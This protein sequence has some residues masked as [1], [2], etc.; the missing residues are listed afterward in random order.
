MAD[1]RTDTSRSWLDGKRLRSRSSPEEKRVPNFSV[2]GVKRIWLAIFVAA[3]AWGLSD[4][5]AQVGPALT[6]P[7]GRIALPGDSFAPP[8]ANVPP[9]PDVPPPAAGPAP[10]SSLAAASSPDKVVDVKV[11]GN[12]SLPLEKILPSIRTRAGRPFDLELIQE[13]V[14]RLDHTHLFVTVKTYWQKVPGGR[15]VI[16][17]VV[18]RP[19]LRSVR[20][21]GCYEIRK[22]TLQKESKL[23][24]GDPVDPISIEE[25]RRAIEEL[26]RTHGFNNATIT[27]LEGSKPEDRHAIFIIDEGVKQ[28]VVSTQ[29]IGNTIASDDRLRTQISTSRALFGVFGGE[30]DRKKLEED[31]EKLTAYY[32]GLGF[33]RARIGRELQF[34][35]Q[36][37]RVT[38]VFV[39]DEG[40]RYKVR[41]VS[42]VG[43]K[44]YTSEELTADLKLKNNQYFNQAS[45][46]FDVRSLQDKYGGDGYVFADIKP[47]PRFLE[48]PGQLDLVYKIAE[49]DR[50]RVGK[51]NIHIKGEY[52]HTQENTVRNR[53]FFKPG[54]IVD[55]RLI[56]ASEV[57]LKRCGLFESN[58]AQGNAP[59]IA[60]N[61]PDREGGNPEDDDRQQ[62]AEKPQAG[63][64]PGTRF[65]GQ[66]PDGASR[67]RVLDLTLECGRYIGPRAEPAAQPKAG[68][69]AASSEPPPAELATPPAPPSCHAST[70]SPE[71][72]QQ[73]QEY[74]E[75]LSRAKAEQRTRLQYLAPDDNWQGRTP[76]RNLAPGDFAAPADGQPR[77]EPSDDLARMAREYSRAVSRIS[78]NTTERQPRGQL[79]LTQYSPDA[80]RSTPTGNDS[81]RWW[82]PTQTAAASADAPRAPATD[83]NYTGAQPQPTAPAAAGASGGLPPTQV[84]PATPAAPY[85]NDFAPRQGP[86]RPVAGPNGAYAP[87]PIFSENSPFRDG[88][89]NGEPARPLGINI[90]TEETM[91]GRLMFGVG[92]NSDAGVV[93]QVILDEQNFNW[94]RWPTSWEDVRNATAFRGAGQRFRLEAMPGTQVQ[95]YAINFQEPFMFGSQVSMSLG[96]FYYNRIYTEYTDQRLGGS[97][98]FGYQFTPALSAGITYTGA[99][100]NITNPIDPALPA[101][102]EVTGRDLAMHNFRLSLTQDKRDNA[103]LATE[104]YLIEGSIDET[105]GSFQYPRAQVDLRKYFTLYE[106]PDGSGRQVLSLMGRAGWSGD[107]TP[108]YDRFYAG[109]FSTIRGFQFRGASPQ[110]VG[111]T[112]GNNIVVG[113]DFEM[114][115]SA[116]YLFPLTADDMVRGVIFCDTGTVEPTINNWSNRYRVAPGFGLRI[117]VPA[118]GPAPIA[119]DFAFPISWQPGDRSELFSFFVGFGR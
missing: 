103:F 55:T 102:A 12:K 78:Q 46:T 111:P 3:L 48:E 84:A 85:G 117:C 73:A 54:D 100:I 27:L 14:R 94:A 29:F 1:L 95:R 80:G 17:E 105:L 90:R 91:T 22:K 113:G 69:G 31:V 97:I 67:D 16:F 108:I 59:K 58:P 32:R 26:Y 41:N 72:L 89:P 93:G 96:G 65:R 114:L 9:G 36:E 99:K 35:D 87:G 2:Q 68:R 39:I 70:S 63:R 30:F 24:V 6:A 44:K 109:G 119:L 52:S 88:P 107:N 77:I 8:P 83:A 18:E 40:V 92:I 4:A 71:L 33:F 79:I 115:V 13:D 76:P 57:A 53:L 106:R 43:N 7:T 86:D 101:L 5:A 20:F 74:A 42:I 23:N 75:T 21:V 37:N 50:Y 56:R 47:D 15:I 28:R 51:I 66:S 34:N 25:G 116:E 49:G 61:P 19:L 38:I 118:M 11:A 81:L 64:R 60:F 82:A 98:G 112:T 62:I 10:A 110:E 45:M 104:G